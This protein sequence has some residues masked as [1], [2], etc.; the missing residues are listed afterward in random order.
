MS[1]SEQVEKILQKRDLKAKA[2]AFFEVGEKLKY[3]YEGAYDISSIERFFDH[4][5]KELIL[6]ADSLTE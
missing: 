1:K 2:N 6:K 4:L 5:A 3:E